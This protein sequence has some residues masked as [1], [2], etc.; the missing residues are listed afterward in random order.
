[1]RASGFLRGSPAVVAAALVVTALAGSGPAAAAHQGEAQAPRAALAAGTISTVAG[2][3]GGPGVA[4]SVAM[5]P[6]SLNFAGGQ[7][8]VADAST[9][10]KISPVTD[11]LTTPVGMGVGAPL[12]DGGPATEAG[13]SPRGTAVDAAGNL[14]LTDSQVNRIQVVAASTGTFYGQAMTAGDIYTIAGTGRSGFS[15]DGGPATKAKLAEPAGLALDA[16]GNVVF[17]DTFNNR[18]RVIAASTGTF[19]G[20]AMT[21]G[22][23]YTVAGGGTSGPGDGGPATS[24]RLYQPNGL[25]V[26]GAGNLVLSDP[27]FSCCAKA[28]NRVRVVADDTGTF[29]GQAMTAGDIYTIAGKG[30][31]GFSG[32][33]GP[34]TSA[35][36]HNPLGVAIDAAGNAL[37]A[38]TNNRRIR[39]VAATTGT[40]YGQAMTTGDIYTI[41]GDGHHGSTGDGG[42]ATS[43]GLSS[44]VAVTADAAGDVLIADSGRV[45]IVA[46]GT[47]TA[48]GQP[49]T[50]GDIYTIGGNGSGAFS[51]DGGPATKAR[52]LTASTSGVAVDAAGNLV[53]SDT[54]NERIRVVAATTGTFYGQAMTAGDIY[55]V[56]GSG[57][58]G[59]SGDGGPAIN[60]K[61]YVPGGVAVDAAGNLLIAD[62]R[63]NRVRVVADHTGTF[64]GQAMTAGDI[65]TVAGDGTLGSSGDG[66]PATSAELAYPAGETVDAA[67]NLLI[68][69]TN[70]GLIRVVAASTGTFYGEHMTAGDI[71]TIAGNGTRGFS[72]DGGPATSAELNAPSGVS[73]DAAGNLLI[74]D[75]DNRRIRVVAAHTGTFYG[76]AM[77]AGDIYAVAGGGTS[78]LG[79]GGPATSAKLNGPADV[80]ADAAGNLVIADQQ[81]NRVRVVAAH[82][83]MFYGHAM[84]AGDI[85]TVAGTGIF[86]FSGD[87]GPGAQADLSFPSGVVSADGNLLISDS[88]NSRIRMVAG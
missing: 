68:A 29:Y 39:V 81:N 86:G 5:E 7:L 33:G 31:G 15:G 67:G 78:G 46:A 80:V 53:M 23:I 83:G 82:T 48:Y 42:P 32:D 85:Y 1:M 28:A 16:A 70:N 8:Y 4:T 10:R 88:D 77:T 44:P 71:Y 64:Y 75:Y 49:M 12:G 11:Q 54:F 17:A 51:G 62:Q 79:D 13:V 45:R 61:F 18:I 38:D 56:A 41:A 60:A 57:G 19:Y 34:G 63:N 50:T 24:A 74:A 37:I 59:F 3:V 22:D 26:D 9:V 27:G 58:R 21:A 25:A 30:R 40:F 6:E 72:G 66:G 55:T 52:I 87:G 76:Q 35:K 43:A 20:T 69:D 65:Y 73:L 14:V 47:G 84:T 2:G 36:L